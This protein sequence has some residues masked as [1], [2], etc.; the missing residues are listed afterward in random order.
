MDVASPA[1]VAATPAPARQARPLLR[2]SVHAGWVLLLALAT[3]LRVGRFGFHPSDQGFILAQAWRVLHGEV[4]HADIISARPLGS[5][6]LHVADYALPMPL[7]FGSSFLSMI[8]ITVAT[9]AFAA[10]VTRRR[11][12][13]WGPGMTA[14]V[15]AASL[16]NLNA[17][18][19]MAWHTVDGIA[20]T[21]CGAWALDAGLGSGRALARRGGLV[22]L[23]CAVFVKQSFA[24]AAVIGVLW[25]L[26]HPAT[27]AGALRTASWWRRLV[28]DLLA[29]AAPG[30]A[31]VAWVSL[32]GGFTEMVE[33]L[34]GG[35]PAYGERLL[36]LWLDDPEVL[37]RAPVRE[38]SF[39]AAIAVVLLAVRLPGD[40]LGVAGRIASWVLVFAGAAAVVWTVVDG[41]FTGSSRWADVLWWI[42]AVSVPV[43]AAVRRKVPWAGLL[44]LATGFMTSLSW[45]NDTPTL[46]TG[47]L[48]LTAL[49]LL[50]HLVPPRPRP[51]RRWVTATAG[52]VAVAVC[53]WVVVA[54]HDQAAYFDLGHDRLTE[55]LGA[56]T[57][58]MAG[59]RTN[60]ST[61][62]FVRQI[63][64][65]LDRFPAA[66]TAILPDSPFAYPA[67]GLRNPFPLEWPLPLEIVG[68]APERMLATADELNREGGYLVLFET[69]S[70]RMLATGGPVPESIPPDTP[71]FDYLGLEKALQARLT[72]RVVTCGSFVGKYA[73]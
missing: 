14:M 66:R 58:A 71:V 3:E 11:V 23:G 21:A 56:V 59:I 73:T 29:L 69:D 47:T 40:R 45:G 65:C 9:I 36:G 48:A 67:F 31:Y 24:L 57:P 55:D 6:V 41:R 17:F 53:G 50:S 63:R 72:G 27:R 35:V 18:P 46:L 70:I 2:W 52:C 61:F 28:L 12:L 13:E 62:T 68:T 30:L 16:I 34:T 20:L 49:L 15:A 22:L 33:Q 1:Q 8:E 5:A 32:G 10:L 7:F 39:F 51:A 37:T 42:V 4:P 60:P 19:L 38:L 64:D 26:L 25:L 43:N 44:V 54:R